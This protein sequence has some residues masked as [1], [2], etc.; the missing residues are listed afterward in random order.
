MKLSTRLL[1]CSAVLMAASVFAEAKIGTVDFQRAI[2]EVKRG[3]AAD[4][5]LR[6]EHEG[7]QKQIDDE[8]NA[9]DKFRTDAEKQ[10]AALSAKKKEEKAMEFQKRVANLQEMGQRFEGE[11][12]KRQV[13]LSQPIVEGL[14]SLVA[15]VSRRRKLDF[16]ME[17]N[18][19]LLYALDKTD[20]TDELIK[21]YDEKNPAEDGKKK[22]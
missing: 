17:A 1:S 22:K 16:V 11:M 18:A 14:R 21:L 5:Q 6:K 4:S 7:R 8:K 15:D 19:G 9:L 13:E 2:R 3:Q 12:Q 20:I 10:A